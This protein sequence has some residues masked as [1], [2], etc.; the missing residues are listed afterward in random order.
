MRES[1]LPT[2]RPVAPNAS[3][4]PGWD[5]TQ[6]LAY[7]MNEMQCSQSEAKFWLKAYKA[8]EAMKLKKK[9]KGKG[10]RC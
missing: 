8:E 2:Q 6:A 5:Y 3:V 10:G 4:K 7:V 1:A 9:G